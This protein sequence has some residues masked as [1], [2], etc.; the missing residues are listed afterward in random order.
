[1]L[2]V[3]KHRNRSTAALLVG[4]IDIAEKGL[5]RLDGFVNEPTMDGVRQD[6]S[7]LRKIREYEKETELVEP[8]IKKH[9]AA[10]KKADKFERDSRDKLEHLR[11]ESSN[12]M[13]ERSHLESRQGSLRKLRKTKPYLFG[14]ENG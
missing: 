10:C 3:I 12:L 5:A 14:N 4:E 1:M 13:S 6:E 7:D 2:L 9:S 11:Q 8:A